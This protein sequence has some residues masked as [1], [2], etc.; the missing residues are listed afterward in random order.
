MSNFEKTIE[1]LTGYT[2]K[3]GVT[4]K[5][6][7]FGRRLLGRD[8]FALDTDPQAT[9]STQHGSLIWAK[10]IIS[11][12]ALKMPI[13]LSVLLDLDSLDRDDVE[14][15]Y[16]KFQ[17]ESAEGREVERINDSTVRLAFGFERE[18]LVYDVAEFGHLLTGRDEVA[19][20]KEFFV[21]SKRRCFL[22]GRQIKQLRQSD[23]QATIDGPILL[24]WFEELDAADI[25]TLLGAGEIFRQSLRR[26]RRDVPK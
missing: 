22:V 11:F 17:L 24:S 1:L 4:H 21:G 2:D 8:L 15:A 19:A 16:N 14:D 13:P 6:V 9:L 3:S 25:V 20:D 10:S 7:T 23:G 18:G 12:G 5:S 26:A